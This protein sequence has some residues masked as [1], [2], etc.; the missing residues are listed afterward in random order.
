M[1][2][3]DSYVWGVYLA[4]GL[5]SFGLVFVVE[6][7]GGILQATLTLN[8]LIGGVTLGLFSLGIF[9]R[10]ANSKGAMIGGIFSLVLVI[11]VGVLAQLN[12][13][14]TLPLPSSIEGCN[15]SGALNNRL[16]HPNG[17]A[18]ELE[19]ADGAVSLALQHHAEGSIEYLLA[20][21]E[22]MENSFY[23]LTDAEGPTSE[24]S[25]LHSD[26]SKPFT[27][28]EDTTDSSSSWFASVYRISYMWYSCLGTLLTVILGWLVSLLTSGDTSSSCFS[29]S[30]TASELP[31]ANSV[32]PSKE[33]LQTV[34]VSGD[35]DE[36]RRAAKLSI[37]SMAPLAL[38]MRT[39]V[40]LSPEGVSRKVL[41]NDASIG[42]SQA[43]IFS[44]DQ[45]TITS[46]LDGSYTEE[47]RREEPEQRSSGG[48]GSN[49]TIPTTLS[50]MKMECERF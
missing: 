39:S 35:V 13:E 23:R 38:M 15:A 21:G 22:G 48:T 11:A 28:R 6:R 1:D 24:G 46:E 45:Q 41:V 4:F 16:L 3:F 44:I 34:V 2:C 29:R 50:S 9:F 27:S 18:Y 36:K 25:S 10:R 14:P 40:M 32:I 42:S 20:T 5:V 37:G 8:G 17:F 47:D 43:S 7:L 49:S 26:A 30:S 31:S 19:P 12:N 33:S